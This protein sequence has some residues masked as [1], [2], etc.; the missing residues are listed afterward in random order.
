MDLY[1]T[2]YQKPVHFE[3]RITRTRW[4]VLRLPSPSMAQ[5]AGMSTEA[6]EDFYFFIFRSARSTTPGLPRP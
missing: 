6:F 3:C 4:C 2:L 1:N 5:Q